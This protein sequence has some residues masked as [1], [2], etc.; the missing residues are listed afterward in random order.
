MYLFR[1]DTCYYEE[2]V[3]EGEDFNHTRSCD[4]CGMDGC[5]ECMVGLYCDDCARRHDSEA[6]VDLA[7]G[8][9]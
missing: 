6:G 8:D 5:R 9:D 1:C 7:E 3:Q 2:T 4:E